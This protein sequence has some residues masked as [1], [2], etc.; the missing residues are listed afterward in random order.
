MLHRL[1]SLIAPLVQYTVGGR[2]VEH[3]ISIVNPTRI[4]VGKLKFI[5][6]DPETVSLLSYA[7]GLWVQMGLLG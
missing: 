7:G 2:Q 6:G 4:G 1:E 3:R 5:I